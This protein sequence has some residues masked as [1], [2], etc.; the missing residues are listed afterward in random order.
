MPAANEQAREDAAAFLKRSFAEAGL[1]VHEFPPATVK[2]QV[3]GSGR[4]EKAQV[5]FMVTRLLSLRAEAAAHGLG[6]A[7][8][9]HP[10]IAAALDREQLAVGPF[11]R[12]DAGRVAASDGK[13]RGAVNNLFGSQRALQIETMARVLDATDRRLAPAARNAGINTW[14]A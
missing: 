4:A 1:P 12:L 6:L 11:A 8:A 10:F 7:A 13:T 14:V 3:T 2:L 5:A 9:G